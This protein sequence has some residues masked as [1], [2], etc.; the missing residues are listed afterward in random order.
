MAFLSR[1]RL[2]LSLSD[3]EQFL[4]GAPGIRHN[5]VLVT[6]DD[7]HLSTWSIARPI[8]K[9]HHIPAVAF[10]TPSMIGRKRG[11]D[12]RISESYAG[13]SELRELT[14]SGVQVA[15]H[16][17]SHRSLGAMSSS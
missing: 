11:F 14:A 13:W 12:E 3:L 17:M 4:A 7:G 10:V 9:R 2:A 16:S 8:L 1:H 15:S 6:I 5:S